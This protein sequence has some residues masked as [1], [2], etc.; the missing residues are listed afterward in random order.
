MS[1]KKSFII[2]AKTY[3]NE[4]FIPNENSRIVF[5]Q[6]KIS[7][8][9][10]EIDVH[11]DYWSLGLFNLKGY[12]AG[13][14]APNCRPEVLCGA[15]AIFLP[16][17]SI[18]EW[19]LKKGDIRWVYFLSKLPIPDS[20]NGEPRAIKNVNF[21]EVFNLI[22]ES[23][24]DL[25]KWT[26][27]Q[28]CIPIGRDFFHH[29]VP[30]RLKQIIDEQFRSQTSLTKMLQELDYSHSMSSRLF[31]KKYGISPSDYRNQLRMKQASIDLL[32]NNQTVEATQ[33]S[34]GINDPSYFYKS[35]KRYINGTPS[36][37]RLPQLEKQT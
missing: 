25:L 13:F 11:G 27:D 19:I 23:T 3:T 1:S 36:Q 20:L 17:F 37:F 29:I 24:E 35:F 6:H 33:M 31:K 4:V 10:R 2:N 26:L 8:D 16:R 14:A 12:E 7:E 18:V 32:F 9:K 15:V 5:R 28:D 34:I 30:E 22:T 21:Q